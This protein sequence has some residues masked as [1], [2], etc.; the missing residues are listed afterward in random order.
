MRQLPLVA[1]ARCATL[2]IALSGLLL[3]SCLDLESMRCPSGLTCPEGKR[4]ALNQDV[5]IDASPSCGDGTIQLGEECDDGNIMPGD[6]CSLDCKSNETCG[7]NVIDSSIGEVCDKAMDSTGD[8]CS[9]DCRSLEGCGNGELD[10]GEECDDN[11][12]END[13]NCPNS[14]RIAWCGDGHVDRVEPHAEE[15]DPGLD[16]VNC[17]QDCTLR[18]CGDGVVNTSAGEQC[19]P[20]ASVPGVFCTS[21][22]KLAR[23]GDGL[24]TPE[25]EEQCDRGENNS[26]TGDCLPICR[27]NVCGDGYLD[28]EG[29]DTEACDDANIMDEGRCPYGTPECTACNSTCTALLQLQGSHCGDGVTDLQNEE[30]CDDG[31]ADACGTCSATCKQNQ[32][33]HASGHIKA[34]DGSMIDDGERIYVSDGFK[35]VVL[36]FDKNWL[37]RSDHK[38]VVI[39][40]RSPA[41]HVADAIHRTI[42][43]LPPGT[44]EIKATLEGDFARLTH[45][46]LGTAGN[47]RITL[48]RENS[49]LRVVGMSGGQGQDCPR[50]M[51][52]TRHKDCAPGLHCQASTKTCVPND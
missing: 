5:C 16:P 22:C 23:C 32:E 6:G 8:R 27:W 41:D 4:C 46:S 10:P 36:E 20:L 34:V 9:D 44:L 37:T 45:K 50:D 15:C 52:C 19:D 21:Q 24:V 1:Q 43:A 51:G 48:S 17:D 29:S 25:A 31:N 39:W 30:V 40:D 7:N 3:S 38:S 13:D 2:L 49:P 26:L 18:Q 47:Q 12:Q 33:R 35:T 14:C 11:N 42:N 28:Q